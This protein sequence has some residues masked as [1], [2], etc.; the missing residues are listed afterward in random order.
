MTADKKYYL[1]LA[2]GC[3]IEVVFQSY[4]IRHI[5]K[6]V[7]ADFVD[8]YKGFFIH[9]KPQTIHFQITFNNSLTA[10]I[11]KKIKEDTGYVLFYVRKK[12]N[13]QT[14]YQISPSIFETII[15]N[16]LFEFLATG[17]KCIIHASASLIKDVAYIFLGQS[18]AGKSTIAK[19]NKPFYPML[20]DDQLILSME[21]N[22]LFAYQTPFLGKETIF[23]R[24]FKKYRVGSFFFLHK[25]KLDFVKKEMNKEKILPGMMQ[26]LISENKPTK[27]SLELLFKYVHSHNNF[28]N[29]HFSKRNKA[30]QK[31]LRSF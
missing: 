5:E 28:Y 29:L 13:I 11:L 31:I 2:G 4:E 3:N 19:L 10:V 14:Y 18:G 7:Q 8:Q 25:S 24:T 23:E 22:V 6:R 16:V 1:Q 26:Q 21:N 17:E 27:K 9:P 20:A 12:N 30:I 15:R